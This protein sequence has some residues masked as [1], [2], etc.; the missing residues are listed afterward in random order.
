MMA[1]VPEHL[2]GSLHSDGAPCRVLDLLPTLNITEPAVVGD[3]AMLACALCSRH[4]IAR[5]F[6]GTQVA[7][8]VVL[9]SI[10]HEE[11]EAL[12]ELEV[13]SG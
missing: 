10:D 13:R 3:A 8:G 7:S 1:L 9:G 5:R 2:L 12:D 6:P 4:V 11:T